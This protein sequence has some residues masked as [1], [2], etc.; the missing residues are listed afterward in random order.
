MSK[1]KNDLVDFV[2]VHEVAM[3]SALADAALAWSAK[4]SEA[5]AEW[6]RG[7]ADEAYRA[8]LDARPAMSHERYRVNA[9][10]CEGHAHRMRSVASGLSMLV[11]RV[12]DARE[13]KKK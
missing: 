5:R 13:A 4:A 9:E 6:E 7:N 10:A 1:P 3:R 2:I 12:E 11:G 8:E